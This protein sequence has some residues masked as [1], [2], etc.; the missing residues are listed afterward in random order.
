MDFA[1]DDRQVREGL[2]NAPCPAASAWAETLHNKRL[3]NMRLGH[4]QI[5]DVQAVVVFGIGDGA[6]ESLPHFDRDTL[7]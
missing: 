2:F 7:A 6:L 4:D 5:V 1:N 3:A